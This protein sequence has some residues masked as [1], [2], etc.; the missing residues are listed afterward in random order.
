MFFVSSKP[1]LSALIHL[2]L[3]PSGAGGASRDD[4]GVQTLGLSVLDLVSLAREVLMIFVFF[5][6]PIPPSWLNVSHILQVA[7]L[8]F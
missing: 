3:N 8:I 7:H 5:H 2:C 1:T 4:G 6:M